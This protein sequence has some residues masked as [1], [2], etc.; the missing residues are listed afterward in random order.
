[1][2]KTKN[3]N[4][5]KNIT[6][7]SDEFNNVIKILI[8][9]LIGVII[10][11]IPIKINNQSETIIYHL[12]YYLENKILVVIEVSIVIFTI[13]ST[14][15]SI[16]QDE[17]YFFYKIFILVRIFSI[18]ILVSFIF[19]K[20]Y[21]FINDDRLVFILRDLITTLIILLPI[22]SVFMPLLIDYGLIEIIEAYTNK[23]M[24]K[25]FKVSGKV[26]LNFLVY[27]FLGNVLGN[28]FTYKLYKDGKLR[29]KEACIT[30]LNF[31]V[32]SL[33]LT[34]DLCNKIN[35]NLFNFILL[36]M[37]VLII[38]NSIICRIYPL[39]K[40]K[41]SYFVKSGYKDVNCKRHK[42][43]VALKKHI[44]RGKEKRFIVY[45]KEYINDTIYILMMLIPSIL[46]I[47]FVIN[48]ILKIDLLSNFFNN[49]L[50]LII[51]LFHL[52]NVNEIADISRMTFFN[53]LLAVKSISDDTYYLTK[54]VLGL[55]ISL[56]CINISFLMPFV[57]NTI[58]PLNIKE[59]L[60]VY[61]ERFIILI[62]I[63]SIIYS[64]YI[65]YI[66]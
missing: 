24:K 44:S 25:L 40:K 33:P 31:S 47:F 43:S 5:R 57:K 34:A 46:I 52:P 37:I 60:L 28:F 7:Q 35:I 54:I 55:I 3:N 53:S 20:E 23:M 51:N 14:L 59:I 41:Q 65:K 29:G 42:L 8:F 18:L 45:V 32:L 16:F 27:L 21:I 61:M 26:F 64:F 1:M 9:S 50:I 2:E 62:F 11:F 66:L 56:Q 39:K 13:L 6:F 22:S 12:A 15:K 19:E 10:F 48:I 38:C 63:S 36:E 30:V 58:I 4:Y 17:K 49:L